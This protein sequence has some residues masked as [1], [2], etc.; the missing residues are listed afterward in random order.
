MDTFFDVRTSYKWILFH[1][2]LITNYPLQDVQKY[3]LGKEW[4]AKVDNE[5]STPYLLVGSVAFIVKSSNSGLIGSLT[6]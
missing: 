4:L 3:M 6:P 5:T 1:R 2:S